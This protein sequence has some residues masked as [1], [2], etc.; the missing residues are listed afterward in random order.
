MKLNPK[1]LQMPSRD[2][3][4]RTTIG[5]LHDRLPRSGI[6]TNWATGLLRLQPES[7]GVGRRTGASALVRRQISSSDLGMGDHQRP[8]VSIRGTKGPVEGVCVNRAWW[9]VGGPS[10]PLSTWSVRQTSY[11]SG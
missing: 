9:A 5:P 6:V 7:A 4:A 11:T 10:P 1:F 2:N 3:A 8:S